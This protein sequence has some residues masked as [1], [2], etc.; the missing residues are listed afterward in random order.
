MK[1]LT[2]PFT[3]VSVLLISILLISGCVGQQDEQ[4]IISACIRLCE[5]E[6][7][8]GTNLTNGPCLSNEIAK[9]WV[10]DVAHSPRINVDDRPEN[11][12]PAFGKTASHFVEVDLEC[13]FIKKY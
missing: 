1:K 2:F 8:K 13:K 5:N 10:C 3:L 9:D 11:Q 4:K 7:L 12:C 6:K